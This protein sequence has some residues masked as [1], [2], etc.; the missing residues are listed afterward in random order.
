MLSH[1]Q[2]GRLGIGDLSGIVGSEQEL[3]DIWSKPEKR[4]H[5]LTVL[6]ET[7]VVLEMMSLS[8]GGEKGRWKFIFTIESIKAL[9]RLHLV[10]S[11]EA[12]VGGARVLADGGRFSTPLRRPDGSQSP[13]DSPS[14]RQNRDVVD[15]HVRQW[16]RE[17]RRGERN[18]GRTSGGGFELDG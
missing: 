11:G 13:G 12:S 10:L 18:T 2:R 3:R 4:Q 14:R 16:R 15:A 6:Q 1:R 7:G 5:F 9:V 17:R 8:R